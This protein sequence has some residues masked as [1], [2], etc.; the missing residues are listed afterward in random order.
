MALR[1][2]GITPK[3]TNSQSAGIL[4]NLWKSSSKTKTR[5]LV[6]LANCIH[7]DK[8]YWQKAAKERLSQHSSG[9]RQREAACL[10]KALSAEGHLRE[11]AGV[12]IWGDEGPDCR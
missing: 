1:A 2:Y 11:S 3:F 10:Y 12:R 4:L 5:A 6:T 9:K 8:S 7:S